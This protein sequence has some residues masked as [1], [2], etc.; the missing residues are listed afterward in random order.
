M[1]KIATDL[2]Q[3]KKLAKKSVSYLMNLT[4][5]DGYVVEDFQKYMEDRV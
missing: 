1:T 3:S 2:E 4:K 5:G